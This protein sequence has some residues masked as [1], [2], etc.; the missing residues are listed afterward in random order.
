MLQKSAGD[1]SLGVNLVPSCP[2]AVFPTAE[3]KQPHNVISWAP[4]TTGWN[5][6]TASTTYHANFVKS[7]LDHISEDFR[8]AF[9][10]KRKTNARYRRMKTCRE[11]LPVFKSRDELMEVIN[12]NPVV[13]VRGSTGCGKTTQVCARNNSCLFFGA[14]F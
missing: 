1:P 9:E 13:L 10:E 3:T 7:S 14:R 8:V 4:P 11:S 5:P 6:W 2:A 12:T